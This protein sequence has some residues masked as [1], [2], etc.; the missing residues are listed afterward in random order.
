M[1]FHPHCPTEDLATEM[2]VN[3][4]ETP[5]TTVYHRGINQLAISWACHQEPAE[6]RGI[7][8]WKPRFEG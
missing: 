5:N 7:A 6:L 8:K 1:S 4:G 3:T 2:C